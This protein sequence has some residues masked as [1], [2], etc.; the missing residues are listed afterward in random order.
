MTPNMRGQRPGPRVTANDDQSLGAALGRAVSERVDA[1]APPMPPPLAVVAD[2]AEARTRVRATR[3]AALAVAASILAV[4][5]GVIG[6]NTLNRSGTTTV[7]VT[8]EQVSEPS[9]PNGPVAGAPES[10]LSGQLAPAGTGPH[11]SPELQTPTPEDL[12]TGPVL[13]WTEIDPGFV[14]LFGFESAGDGRVIAYA[15][16][17]GVEQVLYGERAVVTANG[18]DWEELP[19]PD[20]LIPEEIDISGDRWLVVGRYRNFDAPEGRLNRVFFSDDQGTTWTE[21][22]FDIPPDPALASAVPAREPLGEAGAGVGRADGAGA[23]GL[24]HRRRAVSALRS[25]PHARGQGGPPV[26]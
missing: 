26:A 15:R 18:T 8:S 11:D 2:A 20:G 22:E 9:T 7:V 10:D 17:E 19:L 23:P 14:D 16:P 1:T 21:L 24:H 5:G 6:W 3:R 13:Q 12:S 25:G 4:V